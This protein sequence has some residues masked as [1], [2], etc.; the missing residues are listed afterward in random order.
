VPAIL[1]IFLRATV[2]PPIKLTEGRCA[3]RYVI[4]AI[5]PFPFKLPE[6]VAAK[7]SEATS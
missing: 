5:L 1:R 2:A 6:R 3:I 7:G 4:T